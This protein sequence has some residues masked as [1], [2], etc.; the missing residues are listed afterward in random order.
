MTFPFYFILSIDDLNHKPSDR[1]KC[2]V[3][4][5]N[6]RDSLSMSSRLRPIFLTLN[7]SRSSHYDE[8]IFTMITP[9]KWK[10]SRRIKHY[11][12]TLYMHMHNAV[13]C[14]GLQFGIPEDGSRCVMQTPCS[15]CRRNQ[16]EFTGSEVNSRTCSILSTIPS[17][18]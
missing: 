5:T 18:I 7:D 6:T 14:Q 16:D 12:V 1:R 10:R 17:S 9:R 15:A 3:W 8:L 4:R 11:I 2:G 13:Y